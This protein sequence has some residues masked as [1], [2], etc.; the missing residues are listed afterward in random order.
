MERP[1]LPAAKMV[2]TLVKED[3]DWQHW[4]L[5]LFNT[6]KI[7]DRTGLQVMSCICLYIA[8]ILDE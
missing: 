8:V 7:T 1:S 6:V 2:T 4:T 5:D 3:K